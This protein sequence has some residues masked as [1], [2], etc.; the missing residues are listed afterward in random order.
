MF[1]S[2]A[3]AAPITYNWI[4]TVETAND[5]A[6]NNSDLSIGEQ[7]PISLTLDFAH[8]DDTDASPNRAFYQRST[9]VPSIVR[10]VDIGGVTDFGSF[11]S[12]EILNDVGGVDKF[13][14]NT[15]DP[16]LGGT[17]GF[18]FTFVSADTDVLTSDAVPTVLDPALFTATFSID[19][20]GSQ[21]QIRP[22]ATGTID[23]L[24]QAVPEPGSLA[25]FAPALLGFIK[26]RRR[27]SGGRASSA[28]R[29]PGSFIMT[30]R[31]SPIV[32]LPE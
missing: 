4:G 17:T 29:R 31:P 10:A 28:Q 24:A 16:H 9:L 3:D 19:A 13:M 12:V 25:L 27:K 8:V 5:F 20:T 7:I 22:R 14:I 6:I 2:A 11:Q 1:A 21:E 32:D 26:L 18:T 30:A 15:Y 23:A